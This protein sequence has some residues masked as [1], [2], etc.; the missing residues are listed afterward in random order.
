MFAKMIVLFGLICLPHSLNA[1]NLGIEATGQITYKKDGALVQK[2]ATLTVPARGQG[3][4]VLKVGEK[5]V[6]Y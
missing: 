6:S 5:R 4:V 1:V 3:D 2:D